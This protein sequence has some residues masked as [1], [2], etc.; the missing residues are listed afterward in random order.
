MIKFDPT[1]ETENPTPTYI[2]LPKAFSPNLFLLNFLAFLGSQGFCDLSKGSEQ[3]PF[4]LWLVRP[5]DQRFLPSANL[6]RV[7]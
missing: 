1:L 5:K 3:R 4:L 7:C 6:D 2:A